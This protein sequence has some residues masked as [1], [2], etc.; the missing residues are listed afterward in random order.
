[1]NKIDIINSI[2]SKDAGNLTEAKSA[3]KAL[4]SAREA[5]FRA[6]ASKFVAKSLFETA[7]MNEKLPHDFQVGD[8]VETRHIGHGVVDRLDGKNDLIVKV[9]NPS[10]SP[11]SG[12][13]T[14]YRIPHTHAKKI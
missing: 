12:E 3:I 9:K 7:E 6:D 8:N 10:P 2:L 11:M 13:F 5:Q 4:L 14:Q 1:M